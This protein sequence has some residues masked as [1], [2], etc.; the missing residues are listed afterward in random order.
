M[1]KIV[2]TAVLLLM[3]S[4][5]GEPEKENATA[6]QSAAPQLVTP[7]SA[8]AP[9]DRKPRYVIAHELARM[10][11]KNMSKYLVIDGEAVD[12]GWPVYL[13][14][15]LEE[16]RSAERAVVDVRQFAS[17]DDHEERARHDR[18]KEALED[19]AANNVYVPI[20]SK[21]GA[22]RSWVGDPVAF[23]GHLNV[24]ELLERKE[25]VHRVRIIGGNSA[26]H[27]GWLP[28]VHLFECPSGQHEKALLR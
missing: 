12:L 18:A 28:A 20:Y 16:A 9:Q 1:H 17:S 21:A 19:G 25:D 4:C 24:C 7:Q 3:T 15:T 8:A 2:A 26:G 23:D 22:F 27:T 5:G 14:E 11:E 6:R 13:T 10:G